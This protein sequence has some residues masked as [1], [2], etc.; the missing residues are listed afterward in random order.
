MKGILIKMVSKRSLPSDV[1]GGR[2]GILNERLGSL[3]GT[4][5]GCLF[6]NAFRKA[7]FEPS[8]TILEPLG[9]HFGSLWGAF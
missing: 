7:S 3:L 4:L 8:D 1:R 9:I 2:G 6:L 5:F